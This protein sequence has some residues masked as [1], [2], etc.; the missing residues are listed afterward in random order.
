MVNYGLIMV[1]YGLIM[2]NYGLIMVPLLKWLYMGECNLCV[3][4]LGIIGDME[5]S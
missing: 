5:V 4:K 2:V 1:N 3:V